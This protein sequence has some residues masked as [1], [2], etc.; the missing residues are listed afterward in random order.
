MFKII[1]LYYRYKVLNQLKDILLSYVN[2]EEQ[3]NSRIDNCKN[4]QY[5]Q[6]SCQTLQE[7]EKQRGEKLEFYYFER[8]KVWSKKEAINNAIQII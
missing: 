7:Y 4:S 1:K 6:N 5:V 8:I 3:I 2:E